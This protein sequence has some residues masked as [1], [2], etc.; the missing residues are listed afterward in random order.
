MQP[1]EFKPSEGN[2]PGKHRGWLRCTFLA[3]WLFVIAVSAIDG[4]LAFRHRSTILTFE[5]NPIGRLLIQWNGG[6]VTYLL[7]AKF[8]GTVAACAILLLLWKASANLALIVAIALA[9][10]QLLL[11]IFLLIG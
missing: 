7:I 6:G 9:G 10:A 2:A 1:I 4:Y 5:L 8:A 3:L 11:L